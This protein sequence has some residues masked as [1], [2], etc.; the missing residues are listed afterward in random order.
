MNRTKRKQTE[1]KQTDSERDGG[2]IVVLGGGPAGVV[3]AAGL[4]RLGE[5]IVLVGEPRRFAAVEGVSARVI[6]ALRGLGLL[7][8]V[9]TFA[10][11]S[12]R[13]ATWNGVRSDANSERL[14]D[15]RQLDRALLADAARLGVEVIAGHIAEVVPSP[16]GHEVHV[17]TEAGRRTLTAR[18][19]V[20]ARGRVAPAAGRPRVRGIETVALSQ[21]WQGPAGLTGS[22]VQS[23]EDGWAW[24]AALPDGRRYLQIAIDVGSAALPP[25]K[26]LAQRCAER[27]RTIEAAQPF[28]QD[29]TPLGEPIARA[30]TPVLN[31][32]LTGDDWLRVGDAAMAVDPLSGNGLFQALSSA[33][34]AP[35]VIR[36]MLHSPE[37]AALAREFHRRRIE[38]LFFRFAR[39]GRDF[40]ATE[41]GWADAPFWRA[42]RGWPDAEPLHRAVT[43][44]E[45]EVARRP[46]LDQDGIV[47]ADVVVTPDQPLGIWH[48][49]GLPLAAALSAVRA[50][51]PGQSAVDALVAALAL[52]AARA[53]S[54]AD[55]M[56][57]QGWIDAVA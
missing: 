23:L 39:I 6:E 22:A 57:Q 32:V 55:W 38:H 29:A 26:A 40:Y 21:F 2:P 53:A 31:E 48:L 18:F 35:A 17:E 13:R 25:K 9:A 54:L 16:S 43:P 20:E 3:V 15:R 14:V 37:R 11:P 1:M 45:V 46:V 5:S 7:G 47:A 56:R 52:P 49:D 30:S 19:V 4:A 34:Q 24:M 51:A 12:P 36:T 8:A 10:P 50:A 41:A 27:F 44:A 33:L 42:R 28:L